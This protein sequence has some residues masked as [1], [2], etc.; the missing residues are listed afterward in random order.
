MTDLSWNSGALNEEKIS[1]SLPHLIYSCIIYFLLSFLYIIFFLFPLLFVFTLVNGKTIIHLTRTIKYLPQPKS[2]RH[3]ITKCHTLSWAG[4]RSGT[5]RMGRGNT[6]L[7]QVT[8]K[9]R[10]QSHISGPSVQF[11]GTAQRME[12]HHLPRRCVS[13]ILFTMFVFLYYGGSS[14]G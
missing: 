10:R 7:R 2:S 8:T 14:V 1:R 6:E 11:L 13:I 9:A 12:V 4:C 3:W 5:T